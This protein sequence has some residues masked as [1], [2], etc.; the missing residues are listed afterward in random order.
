MNILYID[1]DS[2]RPDHLGC[3]GYHRDTSPNIDRIAAAGLRFD[4]CYAPDVPCLPSR[5]ALYQMRHGI[6]TG[7]VG[8]GGTTADPFIEGA[9]RGFRSRIVN[10]AFPMQLRQQGYYTGMISPFGERHAAL[11]IYAGFNEIHNPIGKAGN[12]RADEVAPVACRWLEA[13][14]DRDRW[15]L[16][17][18]LWDPHTPY[19]SDPADVARFAD[20]PLPAW[21]DEEVRRRHWRGC[22]PHSAQEVP[23]FSDDDAFWQSFAL[24]PTR[25]DSMAAARAMFDGYDAGVFAA[26]RAVGQIIDCLRRCG[27][28][29][30]TAVVISADHGENLGEL[31]IYGDHQTA[32]Q[33]TGRIP[34]IV[35]WPGLTESRAGQAESGFL[36]H[37]DGFAALLELAGGCV[38]PQ[39]D[40]CSARPLIDGTAAI[41]DALVISQAAWSCQRGVRFGDHLLLRSYHDGYHDLPAYQLFD[42]VADPHEEQDLA[43][44]RP[45][46]VDRGCRLL[47][48]WLA[49]MMR[50]A[51]QPQDPLWT[52]LAE[53]GPFHCRGQLPAYLDRLRATGR[54]DCAE[55]LIAAHGDGRR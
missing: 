45:E 23:G 53:G 6:H 39:W 14:R 2:L 33:I 5:T 35:H 15:F 21:Y 19:R 7:V 38:L 44:T 31:N 11:Q 28:A 32:D 49:A 17:I 48:E 25:I 24:Q 10:D 50:S 29:D 47:D 34:L 3:Y 16:H 36:Y 55:R 12:E 20:D 40:A 43:T 9:G 18:N 30:S 51:S 42:V 41:R 27:L 13:N 37:F 8:H 26:D 1:I 46:L 4:N 52:V 22:G 54:S